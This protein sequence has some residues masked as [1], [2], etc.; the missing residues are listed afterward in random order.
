MIKF[1]SYITLILPFT[2]AFAQ[3]DLDPEKEYQATVIGFYNLENLFDTLDTDDVYDTEYTPG[4]EKTYDSEKYYQ[5]LENMAE[6]IALIGTEIHPNGAAIIG[7]SEVENKSVLDD[8]VLEESIADRNYRVVHYQ[9][10]DERGIDVGLLYNPEY[11]TLISNE[12]YFVQLPDTTDRTRDQLRVTGELNGERVHIMV[13]HWPSRSGGEKRSEGNRAAAAD[14]G[15]SVIDSILLA[16]PDAKIFYMGDL[17]DDPTNKSVEDHLISTGKTK[18]ATDG[19]MYNTTAPLFKEGIGTLAWKD[20]WN[21]FDQILI[22]PTVL[23]EDYSDWSYYATKV[24]NE[25]FLIQASGPWKGYPF[26]TYSGSTWQG[27]YSDHF[28]VYTILLK[29]L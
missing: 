28:P 10:P 9:S 1:F 6:V 21:L 13:V 3:A 2:G 8:L 20:A 16:E 27:G 25:S 24:F 5:K 19:V 11:F 22:S 23:G 14:V 29:E 4:G 26:R 7:V 12:A 15:R 17:N 18:D